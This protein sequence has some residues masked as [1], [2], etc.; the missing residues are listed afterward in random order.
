M[1]NVSSHNDSNGVPTFLFIL[2]FNFRIIDL[3]KCQEFADSITLFPKMTKM[4]TTSKMKT[5]KKIK[6]TSKMKMTSKKK[7]TSK[8]KTTSK[9]RTT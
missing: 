3:G 1:H 4:K 5:T 7:M 9:M 8:M 6:T 2:S